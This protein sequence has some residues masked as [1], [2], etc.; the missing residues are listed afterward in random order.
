MVNRGVWVAA[1]AGTTD[2]K[3]S[4]ELTLILSLGLRM[5][6]DKG[7]PLCGFD[8]DCLAPRHDVNGIGTQ[9]NDKFTSVNTSIK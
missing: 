9:L 3:M 2:N 8:I 1:F 7:P 5:A 4:P 6:I